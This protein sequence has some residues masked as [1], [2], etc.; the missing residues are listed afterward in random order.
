MKMT[1]KY[2]S[3]VYQKAEIMNIEWK[4]SRARK[5]RWWVKYLW[6]K[7]SDMREQRAAERSR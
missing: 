1:K 7:N 4:P 2:E 6:A 5:G 3:K